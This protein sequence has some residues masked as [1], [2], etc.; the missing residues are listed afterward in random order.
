LRPT[1]GTLVVCQIGTESITKGHFSLVEVT[2]GLDWPV[3]DAKG[4]FGQQ[5]SKKERMIVKL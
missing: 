2:R 1:S 4:V 5:Q 3:P